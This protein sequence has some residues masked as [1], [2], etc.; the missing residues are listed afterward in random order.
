[1]ADKEFNLSINV[2]A[3][4]DEANSQLSE[5]STTIEKFG[6]T[7]E[8]TAE[9]QS[10]LTESQT[11]LSESGD[12]LSDSLTGL[13]EETDGLQEA[14]ADISYN[15]DQ[16]MAEF[17]AATEASYAAADSTSD[18]SESMVDAGVSAQEAAQSA[19][20][21]VNSY[22]QTADAAQEAST[23]VQSAGEAAKGTTESS[24]GLKDSLGGLV[25]GFMQ[26]KQGGAD[27]GT[28]LGEIGSASGLTSGAIGELVA[29]I[30]KFGGPAAAAILLGT[31]LISLLHESTEIA[32]EAE[33]VEARLQLK[34]RQRGES[35]IFNAGSM[36]ALASSTMRLTGIDDDLV[37]SAEA[38]LLR[39]RDISETVFPRTLDVSIEMAQMMGT[40]LPSAATLLGRALESPTT[41]LRRLER[42]LGIEFTDAERQ[43]IAL[44]EEQG[45]VAEAQGLILDKVAEQVSGS[46]E[47]MSNTLIGQRN[48]WAANWEQVKEDMGAPFAE[49]EKNV[50]RSLNG[51]FFGQ[52]M[53]TD[54]MRK[55]AVEVIQTSKTYDEYT[56]EL[57]RSAKVAGLMIDEEGNL[58]RM[59]LTNHG[60]RK[61]VVQEHAKL[62]QAEYDTAKA[63]E[64][65]ESA[66]RQLSPALQELAGASASINDQLSA[67]DMAISGPLEQY[68]QQYSDGLARLTEEQ[69]RYNETFEKMG[70]D[71]TKWGQNREQI[72]ALNRQLSYTSWQARQLEKEL[73]LEPGGS[74]EGGYDAR[75]EKL[76][77]LRSQAGMTSREIIELGGK[78]YLTADQAKQLDD[79]AAGLGDVTG[80]MA[81]LNT[82]HQRSI[83]LW[84]LDQ[85]KGAFAADGETTQSEANALADYAEQRGLVNQQTAE[86][87]RISAELKAELDADILTI[88]GYTQANVELAEA[89][90]SIPPE[91]ST[92]VK[93]TYEHGEIGLAPSGVP[94][95]KPSAGGALTQQ[96]GGDY[97][98]DKPTLF[99]AGEAGRPERVRFDPVTGD[100][101]NP[102][103]GGDVHIHLHIGSFGGNQADADRLAK[104]V[105]REVKRN[106]GRR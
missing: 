50:L 7:A 26:G 9:Q 70:V 39:Y 54:V 5:L 60:L 92:T 19:D 36:D 35:A 84:V 15:V 97:I 51:I 14:F 8:K 33:V 83:D 58:Y 71:P 3:N 1:M 37:K 62:T 91:V 72:D 98:V 63:M 27:L 42:A 67:L 81:D 24:G 88:E 6:E 56:T 55:H 32:A 25:E 53:L 93:I 61:E 10:A 34:L 87:M 74:W 64:A 17:E 12:G 65:E 69:E 48:I 22:N 30:G 4:A 45:R 90:G 68:N 28:V 57:E 82:E 96:Y 11:A 75:A 80:A 40:D 73:E 102:S 23:A 38:V 101:Y 76:G 86:A 77:E 104:T 43:A 100:G 89:L 94:N 2:Q 78:P 18:L 47:A 103:G 99:L 44:M 29:G 31:E 46:S 52:E 21:L 79:A 49:M 66:A 106:A 105:A 16:M 41:G 59:V 20:D 85:M 13:G 95:I